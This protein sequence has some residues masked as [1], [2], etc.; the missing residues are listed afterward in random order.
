MRGSDWKRVDAGNVL[1]LTGKDMC[2]ERKR[3]HSAWG[4]GSYSDR[5]RLTCYERKQWNSAWWGGHVLTG[6]DLRVMRGSNETVRD[7]VVMFWQEKTYVLWE[8]AM[9]QC[10][11]GWSCSDRKR[12]T[13]YERKQWN[14]A[15][16]GGHV[17][18]GKDLRVMRGSNEIVCEGVVHVL[19]DCEVFR[20]KQVTF[21]RQQ[22]GCKTCTHTHV[23]Q[24]MFHHHYTWCDMPNLRKH[25]AIIINMI[26]HTTYTFSHHHKNDMP[27]H[28][29]LAIT[30][31]SL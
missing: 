27:N 16:W 19:T 30:I 13:C 18:T 22:E 26:C 2:F 23:T 5:K 15:W 12:L 9:K 8:E 3:W 29:Y 25:L 10:V 28:K 21:L 4:E 24:I 31:N 6:R 7:G 1:I 20:V 11:M 17:L 14:S